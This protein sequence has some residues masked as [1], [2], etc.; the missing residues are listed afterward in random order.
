[1]HNKKSRRPNGHAPNFS[2]HSELAVHREPAASDD[3]TGP[4]VAIAA[5]SPAA[6]GANRDAYAEAAL[7]PALGETGAS[8][9]A[10]GHHRASSESKDKSKDQSTRKS[11]RADASKQDS[12]S[13]NPGER[14]KKIPPAT[15]AL[16][17]DGPEFVEAVH[18]RMDLIALQ[19]ELLRSGDEKIVQRELDC[20]R[21][22]RYGKTVSSSPADGS[23][24]AFDLRN[25]SSASNKTQ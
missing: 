6:A 5:A 3:V 22:L 20:L 19:V 24:Q 11:D 1:M 25:L 16:P 18:T 2:P 23:A 14:F 10:A 15:E 12:P 17:T 7:A 21:D 9:K 8:L 13:N 4:F